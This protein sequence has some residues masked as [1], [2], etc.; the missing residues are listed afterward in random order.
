MVPAGVRCLCKKKKKKEAFCLTV[1]CDAGLKLL[2]GSSALFNP[3]GVST[4]SENPVSCAL[5]RMGTAD[6]ADARNSEIMS[7]RYR[8]T[9][10]LNL[11]YEIH[12]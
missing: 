12:M 6:C 3:G 4:E 9:G 10:N 2:I 8:L 11:R 5:C 7:F 1:S